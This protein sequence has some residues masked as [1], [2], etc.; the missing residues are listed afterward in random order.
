MGALEDAPRGTLLSP[1]TCRAPSKPLLMFHITAQA[2]LIAT[3][4]S[5]LCGK[6]LSTN[7]TM[8]VSSAP[9]QFVSNVSSS[10][11]IDPLTA[12]VGELQSYLTT[13]SVTTLELVD[14][15]LKQIEA[16]NKN[17][18]KLNAI[19]SVAP[20]N[21]LSEYAKKLDSERASGKVRGPL[22]GIPIIVK[23]NIM[24]DSELG[25]DTTC[26]AVALKGAKAG[27]AP[28]VERI[29][30]AGMIIIA[31]ANLSVSNRDSDTMFISDLPVSG[32]GRLERIWSC[33]RVVS[34]WRTGTNSLR[35]RW[36]C[37]WGQNTWAQRTRRLI[38][39]LCSGSCSRLRT[40]DAG[41][42]IRWFHHPAG[43]PV[44]LIWT[45]SDCWC[46]GYA[47]HILSVSSHR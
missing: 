5:H 1:A 25:M 11:M 41:N 8:E 23:D 4:L 27:N 24:T 21:L 15:Y 43:G 30:K 34:G 17:G 32:M 31:K 46:S 6:V 2:V 47:G 33:S 10:I 16:H 19:I 39:W 37:C 40:A 7:Y 35:Q 44:I 9:E 28:I 38:D 20:H 3:A 29:L 12:T 14:I 22:H 13:S 18:L 36:F 42:R 45:Q 26:G